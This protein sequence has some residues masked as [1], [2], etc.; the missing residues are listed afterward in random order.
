M[1]Y[2]KQINNPCEVNYIL[3]RITDTFWLEE[4]F[5]NSNMNRV[6]MVY[7]LCVKYN[8]PNNGFQ[9]IFKYS[10]ELYRPEEEVEAIM[11]AIQ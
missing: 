7:D 10:R 5:R 2:E 6:K 3:S 11:K 4:G 1:Y 9:D 8:L